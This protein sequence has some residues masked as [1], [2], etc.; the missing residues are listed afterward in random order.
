V[1]LSEDWKAGA[2]AE[3]EA[4]DEGLSEAVIEA[5]DLVANLARCWGEER[6]WPV[7]CGVTRVYAAG[8]PLRARLRQAWWLAR[9]K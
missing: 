2:L 6:P 5:R 1:E 4:H 8:Q 9:G 7:L 3:H